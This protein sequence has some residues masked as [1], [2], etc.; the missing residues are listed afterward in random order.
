LAD[1]PFLVRDGIRALLEKMKN[2]VLLV[3]VSNVWKLFSNGTLKK[4]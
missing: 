2:Y 4:T 1:D 3:E